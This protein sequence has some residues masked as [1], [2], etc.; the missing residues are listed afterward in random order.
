[1]TGSGSPSLFSGLS[2]RLKNAGWGQ[3][4]LDIGTT[5]GSGSDQNPSIIPT[6][7]VDWKAGMAGQAK[8]AREQVGSGSTGGRRVHR[9][10]TVEGSRYQERWRQ[11]KAPSKLKLQTYIKYSF[12]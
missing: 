2:I 4:G 5:L 12:F 1:M 7:D 8:K 6:S 9:G 3:A 10:A 11:T